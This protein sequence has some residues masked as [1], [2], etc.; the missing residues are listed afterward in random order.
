VIVVPPPL[1]FDRSVD[2]LEAIARALG[3]SESLGPRPLD[4]FSNAMGHPSV[5][6]WSDHA[7]CVEALG[8]PATERWLE[9][10]IAAESESDRPVLVSMLDAARDGGPTLFDYVVAV[11]EDAGW[12]VELR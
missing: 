10:R 7:A 3:L 5:L 8:I 1:Q 4:A 12:T 9:A 11:F 2:S 6:V